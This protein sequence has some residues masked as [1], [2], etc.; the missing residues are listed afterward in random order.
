MQRITK[1]VSPAV[2][3]LDTI[4]SFL[5]KSNTKANIAAIQFIYPNYL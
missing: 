4:L 3:K 1:S 2:E 5:P